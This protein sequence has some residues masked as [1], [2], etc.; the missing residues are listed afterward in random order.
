VNRHII[1]G[2]AHVG[3]AEPFIVT[4]KDEAPEKATAFRKL[5]DSPVLTNIKVAFNGFE[6]YDVEP[7]QVPDLLSERPVIL[8]GKWRGKPSGKIMVKG[9]SGKESYSKEIDVTSPS[10]QN[11]HALK[12]LWARERIKLL[13]DYNLLKQNDERIKEV[14]NL[15]LTYN[16]LTAYTSFIAV[17]NLVR[18]KDGKFETVK[19]PLPLPQGVSDYAVAQGSFAAAPYPMGGVLGAQPMMRDRKDKSLDTEEKSPPKVKE[20]APQEQRESQST[21]KPSTPVVKIETVSAS[22][23]LDGKEVRAM[24]EKAS[25]H[26]SRCG[27]TVLSGRMIIEAL[28]NADG[29]V[30]EVKIHSNKTGDSSIE[31]CIAQALKTLTFPKGSGSGER[32]VK[33]VMKFGI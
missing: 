25:G 20:R 10:G 27:N 28:L 11:N 31:A 5:I 21:T 18:N 24:I 16:L 8:F 32:W 15:G 13:S 2:M 30:K 14:T 19:Q 29:S 1:E 6:A 12:Y 9:L 17:D 23:G 7:K 4:D 22:G 33:V 3:R 26:L